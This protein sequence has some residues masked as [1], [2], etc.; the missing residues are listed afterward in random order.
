MARSNTGL[1]VYITESS[2]V[3]S[4]FSLWQYQKSFKKKQIWSVVS[5]V[6]I[7]WQLMYVQIHCVCAKNEE[8]WKHFFNWDKTWQIFWK[9][10]WHFLYQLPYSASQGADS[11]FTAWSLWHP[12]TISKCQCRKREKTHPLW[13]TVLVWPSYVWTLQCCHRS[14]ILNASRLNSP[15]PQITGES[16]GS[17]I[18]QG[19]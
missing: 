1:P 8:R 2:I 15:P 4:V 17:Q 7:H 3:H 12:P 19:R 16:R 5:T 11:T 13:A 18:P 10:H 14:E 9:L 6:I